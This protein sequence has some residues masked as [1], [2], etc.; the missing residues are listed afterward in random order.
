MSKKKSKKVKRVKPWL[1]A[2]FVNTWFANGAIE[3]FTA[4]DFMKKTIFQT[5]QSELERLYAAATLLSSAAQYVKVRHLGYP[6]QPLMVYYTY[7]TPP[8]QLSAEDI[9]R[10]AAQRVWD[11]HDGKRRSVGNSNHYANILFGIE[12]KS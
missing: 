11:E 6:I 12:W 4:E 2:T 5:T 3:K 1:T 9:L 7:F 8:I 10:D